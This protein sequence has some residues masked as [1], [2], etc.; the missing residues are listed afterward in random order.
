ML[1]TAA[2]D[3]TALVSIGAHRGLWIRA[4]I[5]LLRLGLIEIWSLPQW[6]APEDDWRALSADEGREA[7]SDDRNWDLTTE[8]RRIAFGITPLGIEARDIWAFH[9]TQ[10]G[11]VDWPR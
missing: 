11:F 8:K 2:E 5:E 6:D 4:L 9:H 7:L 1:C 10:D 3:R